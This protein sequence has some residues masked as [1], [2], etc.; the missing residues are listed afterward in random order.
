[1]PDLARV[2]A[3]LGSQTSA[4]LIRGRVTAVSTGLLTV[5]VDGGTIERVP[6]LEGGW[7][8]AVNDQVFLLTQPEFGVIALGSPASTTPPPA[9]PAPQVVEVQP[10]TLSNYELPP[11]AL[12]YVTAEDG[13]RVHRSFYVPGS[14]NARNGTLTQRPDYASSAVWFY[15]SSPALAGINFSVARMT[16]RLLMSSGGP[17]ELTLHT[18]STP[19]GSLSVLRT[20]VPVLVRPTVNVLSEVPL[21]LEWAAQLRAGTAR[22]ITACSATGP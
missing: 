5:T 8:P 12:G 22:G 1:M 9:P 7:T 17:V 6:Y 20:A 21:P 2:L 14:W 18:T 10:T 4:S 3:G 11:N 19:S 13:S 16:M 15:S